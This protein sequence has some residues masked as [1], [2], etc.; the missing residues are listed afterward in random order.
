MKQKVLFSLFFMCTFIVT[1][2]A[3]QI[4]KGSIWLGGNIGFNQNKTEYDNV[5]PGYKTQTLSLSP[6]IGKA[7]QENLI[8]GVNIT[9]QKTKTTNI[10]G[11][12]GE[13]NEKY[14]GGGIFVR[15]Y[16]PVISR[17]YVFGD[18]NIW[19]RRYR[20]DGVPY[21][22]ATVKTQTKGGES[23]VSL[24]PGIS[25]GLT[26]KLHLETGFNSLLS[27]YYSKRKT[28]SNSTGYNYTNETFSA[29]FNLE[30]KSTFYIGFRLLINNKA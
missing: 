12:T 20:S 15:R 17:L 14:Y 6:T 3:Q 10:G 11:T 18:L 28:T 21:A 13:S 19:A 29:G 26:K 8:V 27:T 5:T 2:R 16:V 24:T 4:N 23:G 25:V 1:T 22:G 7:V 9:Y 30:N